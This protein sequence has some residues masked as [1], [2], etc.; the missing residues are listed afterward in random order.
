MF[1]ALL[2]KLDMDYWVLHC[3]TDGYLYLVFQRRFFKLTLYLTMLSMLVSVVLNLT[4]HSKEATDES[5]GY[6][7]ELFFY[8][9]NLDNKQFESSFAS[10]FHVFMVF[11]YT[12]L[13]I[14]A[15]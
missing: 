3:G 4:I 7:L 6:G 9:A 11:V 14:N 5:T 2:Y 12:F 8:R 1:Y 15:V 13:T 10:Y